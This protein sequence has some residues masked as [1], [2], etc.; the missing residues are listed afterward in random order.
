M[1]HIQDLVH[2]ITK[3]G[4]I[5]LHT[6]IEHLKINYGTIAALDLDDSERSMRTPWAPAQLIE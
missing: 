3:F 5:E 6:I 4:N 1:I 2:P